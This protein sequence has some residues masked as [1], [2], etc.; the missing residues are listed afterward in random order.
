MKYHSGIDLHLHTVVSDGTDLPAEL[1]ALVRRA[2]IGLFSVTDH[3]AVKG[4]RLLC[5]LCGA[6]APRFLPGVE[7]SCK[8]ELGKYH[9]LGYGYDPESGP[10]NEAVARGHRLRMKKVTARLDFL[11]EEFGFSFPQEELDR[12]LALDN[13]GKPHIG[14]LM[15]RY[16]Y[17]PTKE[18]AIREYIDRLHFPNAYLRPEEAIEGI[19]QSGGIPVLAHPAY[20][21]GDQLILGDELDTRVRR[22]TDFG[23]AGL[24][25]FY[26]G[27]SI[28]I[29]GEVLSLAQRLGLYV[30]AGSDYHGKNKLVA[31][32]DTGLPA[33]RADW[34]AGLCRF[35]NDAAGL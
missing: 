23:L 9:I 32:G 34:P 7:F 30:T 21:S 6:D 28:K 14:N 15:V 11:R 5:G 22:L 1:P 29:R 10:I 12:L 17:A 16:G 19:R 2:G 35:L 24:E 20:G 18:A 25:G 27:F 26:S 3:D 13:P 4:A 8:D 33:D 31:L